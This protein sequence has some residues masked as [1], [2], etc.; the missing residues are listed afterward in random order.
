MSAATATDTRPIK[1]LS[2]WRIG[3][4]MMLRAASIITLLF[5]AGHTLGGLQSWSPAGETDVFREM[6]SFRFDADGVSRTYWDFYIGFG[7]MIS[8]FMLAQSAVLWQ[9]AGISRSDAASVRPILGVL[10]LSAVAIAALAW[11]F[12]FTVPLV[13]ALAITFSLG[14]ALAVAPRQSVRR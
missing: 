14:L 13:M 4:S 11:R 6:R 1:R 5:A 10:L 8:V 7:L 12:F 2:E 9:L 3:S